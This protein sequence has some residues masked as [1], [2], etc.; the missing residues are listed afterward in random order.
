VVERLLENLSFDAPDMSGQEV[1]IDAA[2]VRQM[3]GDIVK[4]EDLSRYI[5]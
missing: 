1:V 3:L 5:L 2:Y 4:N